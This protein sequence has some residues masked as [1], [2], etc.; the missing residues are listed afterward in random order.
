MTVHHHLQVILATI[1]KET[2]VKIEVPAII[3][4]AKF[5]NNNNIKTSLPVGNDRASVCNKTSTTNI[6]IT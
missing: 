5:P 3:T 6:I 4:R 2:K 1:T